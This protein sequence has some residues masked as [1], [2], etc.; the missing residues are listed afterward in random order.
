MLIQGTR[1]PSQ[2]ANMTYGSASD[3][4]Q[5]GNSFDRMIY[6]G[7]ILI[8]VGILASR[9]V[10]W[11][12]VFGRNTALIAL[13]LLGLISVTWSDFPYIAI[14]RWFRDLGTYLMIFV[15]M[16]EVRPLESV[17]TLIRRFC[18]VVIPLSIVLIKYYP[19]LGMSYEF[20]NGAQSFTGVTVNKNMLGVLCLVSALFFTWDILR[21]FPDR[22]D[23]QIRRVLWIDLLLLAMT[24]WIFSRVDSSTSLLSYVVALVIMLC[25]RMRWFREKPV[26]L[27]VAI[28][29]AA[30]AFVVLDFLFGVRSL[31]TS[32]VGRDTTFTGR[33]DLWN[34]LASLDKN[35]L[36]GVGYESFWVGPRLQAAWKIFHWGPTE[37]HNGYLEMYIQLGVLG[38]VVL[39]LVLLGFYRRIYRELKVNS[40]YAVLSLSIFVV[41]LIYNYTEAAF[42]NCLLWF[43]FLMVNMVSPVAG[44]KVTDPIEKPGMMRRPQ[45]GPSNFR[46]RI[47]NASH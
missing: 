6:L 46:R 36:L 35:W 41:L 9:S 2:W 1:L 8:A 43:T 5:D 13:I 31:V 45:Y 37:A 29:L 23:K 16:T 18:Y 3:A 47:P 7:L 12:N 17:E 26:R 14:K 40:G 32:S 28:P 24:L 21:R 38:L 42:R 20:Y 25:A 4:I 22:K 27:A 11:T 10:P 33:I 34:Y 30:I 19:R 39:T 44:E 15:Q